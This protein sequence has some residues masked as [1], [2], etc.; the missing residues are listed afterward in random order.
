MHDTLLGPNVPVVGPGG[1][2]GKRMSTDGHYY[3][4]IPFRHQG[5]ETSGQGG[6][7]PMG[8][9]Y[10][11]RGSADQLRLGRAV[12]GAARQLAATRGS[13]GGPVKYGGRLAAGTGGVGKLKPHHTTDIYAGMVRQEKTYRSATQSTYT[14]FRIIS[15]KHP[16]K[17]LHP[18]LAGVH[19]VDD[20]VSHVERIAPAAF[21]AAAWGGPDR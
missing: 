8:A 3:R 2:K 17:W 19:I 11:V 7:V 9:Q 6:G 13:P 10:H 18:G 12:M 21:L 16:E 14:T 1:G 4:A 5:P 15:S 20:V